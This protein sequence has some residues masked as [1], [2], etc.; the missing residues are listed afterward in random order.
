MRWL[1]TVAML[2]GLIALAAIAEDAPHGKIVY[3]RHTDGGSRIHV[4]NA[5]GS[6]D[7]ELPGQNGVYSL[8][9]AWSP[10]GK[11]LVFTET[12]D[13]E[14]RDAK[15]VIVNADGSG[16]KELPAPHPAAIMP[17]WSPDGKQIAFA[18]GD[19]QGSPPMIY[20]S[21]LDGNNVKKISGDDEFGFG[22]FWTPDGKAIGY[23]RSTEESGTKLAIVLK[24]LEDGNVVELVGPEALQVAAAG[25]LSPDGKRLLFLYVTEQDEPGEI[26]VLGI[27]NQSQSTVLEPGFGLQERPFMLASASWSPDG[28]SFVAP[29]KTD[30]GF[31]LFRVSADG[32]ERK[33]LTPEGVDC[34]SPHW[35]APRK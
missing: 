13:E 19:P 11:R 28:K 30:Q 20:V 34:V 2:S 29:I 1:L 8:F 6:G 26:R 33:R 5:D 10:D 14:F 27:E 23:S 12:D 4:M 17:A 24:K 35:W 18:S 15:L 32:K 22:P 3:T 31:G 9:P 7:R 16:R 25:S 21:D